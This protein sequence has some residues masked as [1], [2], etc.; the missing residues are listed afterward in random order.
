MGA[1]TGNF[2]G[3]QGRQQLGLDCPWQVADFV[4]IKSPAIGRTKPPG[5]AAGRTAVCSGGI[6]KQLGVSVSGA[7][8]T[9]ID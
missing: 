5:A 7:D 9:A 6:A 3:F 2:V 1:H 8:G 4:Q